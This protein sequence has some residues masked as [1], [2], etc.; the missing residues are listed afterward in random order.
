[1]P[2]WLDDVERLLARA[3]IGRFAP[4]APGLRAAVLVPLFVDGG[5]LWV[6][7]IRRSGAVGHHPGQIAFPGGGRDER[8]EDEVATALRETRE[9]LGIE[10]GQV[11][12][13]GHLSDV[14]TSSGYLVSPVVGA[15]PW[16]VSLKIAD[17][18]VEAVIRLPLVAFGSPSLVEEM[19][20]IVA[21]RPLASPVFH[22]GQTRIWGATARIIVDL[23]ERL[24][25]AS[26]AG[27]A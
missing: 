3:P 11:M 18:E 22:Y 24:S 23:V 10:P 21:G 15:I 4:D 27:G 13:L 7:F 2:I 6:L 8:D 1:M 16:P 19:E 26:P 17:S 12:I 9:E 20:V 25:L 5:S 14:M